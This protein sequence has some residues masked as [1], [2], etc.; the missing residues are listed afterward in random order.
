M[1][2]QTIANTKTTTPTKYGGDALNNVNRY[3]NGVNVTSAIGT[4]IIRTPTKI[5]SGILSFTN[6][7]EDN[8]V[9]INI[10]E[11]IDSD[12]IIN[13]VPTNVDNND[14]VV[15]RTS[16]Q[17]IQGKVISAQDNTISN[18][19]ASNLSGAADILTTTN[20]KTA[21]NKTF[22]APIISTI[23][24][25]GTITLPTAT[26]TLV[27]RDTTDTL[28]NKTLTS[29]VISTISN[30]GTITLPTSTDTLVGRSTTDTLITKT[31]NITDNTVTATS[32]AT[33]D[34]IKDDGTKFAK[35][36]RGTAGQ[37]LKVNSAAS[38]IEWGLPNT[39]FGEFLYY[40][41][42]DTADSNKYKALNLKTNVVE[43]TS[44]DGTDCLSVFNS[45]VAAAHTAKKSI[46]M[47]VGKFLFSAAPTVAGKYLRIVGTRVG[48]Y[49]G[50]QGDY[51]N[52]TVLK[53]NYTDSTNPFIHW[54]ARSVYCKQ[55]WK[56]VVIEGQDT[57]AN[58]TGL[59]WEDNGIGMQ[60]N[61]ISEVWDAMEDVM[62]CHFGTGLK[63]KA[64]WEMGFWNVVLYNLRDVGIHTTDETSPAR[65]KSFECKFWGGEIRGAPVD[66]WIE[67][68][69]HIAFEHYALEGVDWQVGTDP[70]KVLYNTVNV[71]KIGADGANS[72][73]H[74]CSFENPRQGIVAVLDDGFGTVID[75][76]RFGGF[77]WTAQTIYQGNVAN[78]CTLINNSIHPY[79]A[80]AVATI[81]L[82][83]GCSYMTIMNNNLMNSA[84]GASLV[85][86]DSSGNTVT[87]NIL[88]NSSEAA[89][90]P[91]FIGAATTFR[92]GATV[93]NGLTVTGG[94]NIS[95]ATITGAATVGSTLGVTGA[96]TFSAA[97]TV[98]TTLGVT[99]A[100]TLSSTLGVTGLSTL[101]GKLILN[102]DHTS[103]TTQPNEA[104]FSLN[105]NGIA[106]GFEQVLRLGTTTA[107]KDRILIY[108][109][110]NTDNVFSPVFRV[111]SLSTAFPSN[112]ETFFFQGWIRQA[113]TD[114]GTNNNTG[115]T[116]VMVFQARTDETP[117]TIVN[118]RPMFAF[119]NFSTDVVRFYSEKILLADLAATYDIELGTTNGSMLGT[120]AAQ[121]L[122][123]WGAAPVVQP[124]G[125]SDINTSTIDNA[126]GA[127]ESAVLADLRTKFNSLL[128]KLES[129]G[130][131]GVA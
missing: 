17:T 21:T 77:S 75:S 93:A 74:G 128:A 127:E 29:P 34:L 88:N 37:I 9:T 70:L 15:Y 10:P 119:R 33:G 116:A 83:S 104:V 112:I 109:A 48:G 86:T 110:T 13:L 101:S 45:V 42:I 38:D 99:G 56:R 67:K 23:S 76:C 58:G 79:T 41:Y 98:G 50:G 12:K 122:G 90:M 123:F 118:T 129:I 68:G 115:T 59:D 82:S 120:A 81:L 89:T 95:S 43:F 54:D 113:T 91:N 22:T 72:R 2:A 35:F 20:I 46:F 131:L 51:T 114:G 102:G 53:K 31:I 36:A 125:I 124:A 5:P 66:V 40:M 100:T 71:V 1:P 117:F 60:I 106:A 7:S 97:A 126:F 61:S 16:V 73:F 87:N 107:L 78:K 6:P 39:G 44:T 24:N 55:Q 25:T 69:D 30:T 18:I 80:S 32:R 19:D 92:S 65:A 4:P 130:I 103:N 62:I 49:A 108:N 64:C 85:I 57:G 3:L 111:D 11:G 26:T 8:T 121:K 52:E 94:S 96:A 27:G 84:G 105:A 47:D 14:E 28:T 63:L